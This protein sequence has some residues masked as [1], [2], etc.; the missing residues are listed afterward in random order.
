MKRITGLIGRDELVADVVREIRKGKHLLLTGSVGIGK[1]RVLE[2]AIKRIER[3]QD[4]LLQAGLEF[5]PSRHTKYRCMDRETQEA[6]AH[7]SLPAGSPGQGSIR[8][9]V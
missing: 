4:K 5:N 2:A 3:R 6:S 1:S 8:G 7:G 9:A